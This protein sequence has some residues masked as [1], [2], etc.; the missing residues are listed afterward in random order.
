[1][2]VLNPARDKNEVKVPGGWGLERGGGKRHIFATA[3]PEVRSEGKSP[4][5]LS[6]GVKVLISFK[7]K[8]VLR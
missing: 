3:C 1:M 8:R 6:W 2:G 5:E 7:N 4:Y